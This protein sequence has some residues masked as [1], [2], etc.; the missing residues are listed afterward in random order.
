MINTTF[1]DLRHY[2]IVLNVMIHG[3][4]CFLLVEN[5]HKSR[6][7]ECVGVEAREHKRNRCTNIDTGDTGI[8]VNRNN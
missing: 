1:I 7:L 2:I 3:S 5:A 8:R 6:L 4:F